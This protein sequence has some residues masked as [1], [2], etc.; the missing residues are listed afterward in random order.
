MPLTH[1]TDRK[2]IVLSGLFLIYMA[3][4][5]ITLH[6]LPLLYPE[7]IDSFGW[8]ASEVTLPA[9]VFFLVGAVTSPPA[10]WLLDRFS[11]RKIIMIGSFLL[12]IALIGFSLVQALWQLV[13]VYALL[14]LGLSLCGLVSN[15][16]VLTD[17]F[18]QKRG[19]ATGILLMASS[20]GGV[21]FPLVVGGS[22]ATQGWR[23]TMLGVGLA[24]GALM[25]S[26]AWLLLRDNP[27][28]MASGAPKPSGSEANA[29]MGG[30]G[31][32]L[33]QI[34]FYKVLF[35]TGS[36]WFVIIALT[37]HQSIYLT[38]DV[39]LPKAQLPSVFSL[40]FACSVVGKFGFGILSEYFSVNRVMAASNLTLATALILLTQ[41]TVDHQLLLF[42][43]AAV[44]GIGFS[45]A[46]TCIQLVVAHLYRGPSYGRILAV[47][48][49]TDTLCGALGTRLVAL[50]REWQGAYLSA[51]T[52]MVALTL[53][54]TFLV[55]T[56]K[57]DETEAL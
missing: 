2:W 24:T 31:D 30:L 32:A 53:I 13:V 54:A 7:L 40:F 21:L 6:T 25:I 42:T 39:G 56:L 12:S 17:W 14:G 5:G 23:A 35:L 37:Q 28:R 51:L 52:G 27:Y 8:Q 19:R 4:N 10:G 9:T 49:L 57:S 18:D 11:P 34:K 22:L 55:M 1:F 20:L 16:V 15:M 33:R 45:G 3:S 44:A 50:L 26:S 48:V 36:L 46:F 47:V 41:V 38:Q 29:F 43:Y